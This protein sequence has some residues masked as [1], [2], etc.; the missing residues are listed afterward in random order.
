MESI[1]P[2]KFRLIDVNKLKFAIFIVTKSVEKNV[3]RDIMKNNGRILSAVP[4][5]GISRASMIEVVS[6]GVPSVVFFVAVRSEDAKNLI[7][8]VAVNNNFKDAGKGT[9]FLLDIDGHMGGKAIFI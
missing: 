6:G 3:K 2:K 1:K 7:K 9:A 5:A 8:K 4:G